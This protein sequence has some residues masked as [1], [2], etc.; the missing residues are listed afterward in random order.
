MHTFLACFGGGGLDDDHDVAEKWLDSPEI[1]RTLAMQRL[2][3]AAEELRTRCAWAEVRLEVDWATTARYWR[4]H[5]EPCEA[6]DAETAEVETL[7]ERLAELDFLDD[8]EW[9]GA[10]ATE[11]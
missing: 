8:D 9:T 7:T 1:L 10:I 3:A 2:L 5:P 4:V 6:T 11:S